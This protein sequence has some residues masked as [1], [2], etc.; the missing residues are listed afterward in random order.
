MNVDVLP[1][2]REDLA[3]GYRF[4]EKQSP[5]LGSYFYD[6]LFSDIELIREA[7]G[8]HRIIHGSY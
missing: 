6:S 3:A 4:Y 5:G 2:A 1:E 7:P 8:I